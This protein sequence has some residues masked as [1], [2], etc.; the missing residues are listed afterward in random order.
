MKVRRRRSTS[1][2]RRLSFT[3]SASTS[4]S[5]ARSGSGS[6]IMRC[7]ACALAITAASG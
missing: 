4:R 7:A 2:A 5:C 3:M 1:L 6:A